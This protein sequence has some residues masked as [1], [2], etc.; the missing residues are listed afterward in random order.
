MLRDVSNTFYDGHAVRK[1][2]QMRHLPKGD[3]D[4]GHTSHI[5]NCHGGAYL[6]GRLQS[7]VYLHK[8][9]SV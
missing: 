3:R 8:I 6:V 1:L 2:S 9:A 5:K 7:Y 4:L